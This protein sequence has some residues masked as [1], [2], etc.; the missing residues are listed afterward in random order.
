MGE[1][2]RTETQAVDFLRRR[3]WSVVE[4]G[5]GRFD[6]GTLVLTV[7]EMI[8]KAAGMHGRLA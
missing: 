1:A 4:I 7:D 6:V 8:E 3:G 5:R 2:P